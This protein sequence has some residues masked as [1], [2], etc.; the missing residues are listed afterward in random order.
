VKN[1]STPSRDKLARSLEN[2]AVSNLKNGRGFEP[3]EGFKTEKG[4]TVNLRF[5]PKGVLIITKA[6]TYKRKA[7][8]LKEELKHAQ[9]ELEEAKRTISQQ[10]KEILDLQTKAE[11]TTTQ[12]TEE[13]KPRRKRK[14]EP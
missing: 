8:K 2:Y 10:E 9:N 5:T 1:M 13:I 12:A 14:A 11:A 4:A 6:E 7:S 3:F